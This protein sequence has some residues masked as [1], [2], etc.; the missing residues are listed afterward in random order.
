MKQTKRLV[1]LVLAFVM[2]LGVI[3]VVTAA[4]N[5]FSD[6][7]AGAY[8]YDAVLWA[9]EN[10][11]TAGTSA[12]TFSPNATCTR[13]Q[14]VTFLWRSSGQPEPLS[15]NCPFSDVKS[16]EYYYKAALWAV[17]NNITVGTS[18]TTFSPNASC[19]RGQ[20]VTFLHRA[21]GEPISDASNCQFT[22]IKSNAYY[23]NAVLW[24]V[25]NRVTSGTSATEFSPE[26]V[27]T[28]GQIVTFLY[29]A[30]VGS[31]QSPTDY[32]SFGVAVS[33]LIKENPVENW[34][35]AAAADDDY[36]SGRLI[37]Q[38]SS[39]IDIAQFNPSVY[40]TG[41]DNMYIVQFATSGEAERAFKSLAN[42]P[43]V[44]YVE[45]DGYL[46]STDSQETASEPKSWG[47]KAIGADR[48]AEH[49]ANTTSS[50][51][52]VA[53]VDTG[54][55][56][57]TFLSGRILS[58]GYDFVDNDNTPSDMHYHGT[59]VAGTIVDCTPGIN[60]YILPIRV[61]D[62][63]GSGYNSTVGAGIR[64]AADHG[65]K[66]INLSL[67][68]GHSNY[69]DSAVK[70]AI[71][72]GVCV[73]VAAGNDYGNTADHCPAHINTAITVGAVDSNL[74]RAAFSNT[75][76]SLDV[77]CPGVGIVSCV[78]GGGYRSLNGTSMATPH[79]A[80][81]VA[82]LRLLYPSKNPTEIEDLLCSHTVDLGDPGW[83]ASY[84]AG[85]PNLELYIP[86][87]TVLPTGISLNKTSLSLMEGESETLTATV[88]PSNATDKT[89]TWSSSNTSV[90][91]VSSSGK[92]TAKA[93]GSATITAKT[94]N[95]KTATCSVTVTAATVYPTGISL[96][97]TSLSL[98]EGESETLTATVSPSNATDKTVTW[99]SS[100]TSVATVSSS[101][102]VTAKA[103]GSATITAKTVNGKTATCSVTVA[104]EKK[105]TSIAVN[106]LPNK[107]NY[108]KKDTLVTTGLSLTCTYNDGSSSVVDSGYSC[109]P[110]QLDNAGTQ[111]ITVQYSGCST[112]FTVTVDHQIAIR[113]AN[114]LAN[115][116]R[117]EDYILLNDIDLSSWGTWTPLCCGGGNTYG[118]GYNGVFDGNGHVINNMTVYYVRSG[119]HA[120]GGLFGKLTN[121][122]VKNLT[123]RNGSIYAESN[124]NYYS[125]SRAYAG[126]ICGISWGSTISSCANINTTVTTVASDVSEA[127]GIVGDLAYRSQYGANVVS[128]CTNSGKVFSAGIHGIT[129][130]I[131]VGGIVGAAYN[132][133]NTISGCSNS[134]SVTFDDTEMAEGY[135]ARKGN[136]AGRYGSYPLD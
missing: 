77:V 120:Y 104:I 31:E 125:Y 117:G 107:T 102:K 114:D 1:A 80:A 108:Y 17:E 22:D 64:Y 57:H 16:N 101:G 76:S 74:Q 73:V 12:S 33:A 131:N 86:E 71:D 121:A 28:R 10:N 72:K 62:E 11:V 42:L 135:T 25:E 39:P 92:V 132:E 68:G 55:S 70:Y 6:V 2:A 110:M 34:S 113:T 91:T 37:V 13:A 99:S 20:V 46:G 109:S 43:E 128:L 29:R 61:L 79:A 41:P 35:A 5:P 18:A 87:P 106:I 88:S 27:C 115:V 59:H 89:V 83:D 124:A 51:I 69:V 129:R 95:G 47:V 54:V 82:M 44:I 78:P 66:V 38:A 19:T 118:D 15:S 96:N 36:Y 4:S 50:S 84:G 32:D 23:Y 58:G 7:K 52:T 3:P 63:N 67:G 94:V 105:L 40:I 9:V 130:T 100:N 30:T 134:G 90:A 112:T 53:V 127:G 97:K 48:L 111:T 136:I 119:S 133:S 81:S 98:M 8:Y 122:T 49:V 103:A 56:N 123:I 45:P 93:A 116:T 21:K 65:A 75:G 26:E 24:A 126:A 85:R 14:I 60:V